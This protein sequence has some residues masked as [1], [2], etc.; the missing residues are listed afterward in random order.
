MDQTTGIR[1]YVPS[2]EDV[3]RIT[4]IE[5]PLERKPGEGVYEFRY[6]EDKPL[7]DLITLE[8]ELVRVAPKHPQLT[9]HQ[10]A[11]RILDR[12]QNFR[13]VFINTTTGEISS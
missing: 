11:E 1:K 13:R 7:M 10:M 4:V 8:K 2:K 3:I 5:S 6:M 9:P 12:L